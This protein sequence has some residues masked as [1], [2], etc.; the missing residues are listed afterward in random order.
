MS[1]VSFVGA[2]LVLEAA[3]NGVLAV[4]TDFNGVL[5]KRT[6]FSRAHIDGYGQAF[7]SARDLEGG[8]FSGAVLAGNVDPGGGFD[9]TG[10]TLTGATFDGAQCVGCNFT[11]PHLEHASFSR[12]DAPGAVFSGAT[13]TAVNLTDAWLDRLDLSNSGCAAAPGPQQRWLWP[14]GTRKRRG[15]RAGAIRQDQPERSLDRGRQPSLSLMGTNPIPTNGCDGR[16]LPA[17]PDSAP[18]IPAPCSAAALDACPTPTS[19]RFDATSIG[20]P[21]AWRPPLHPPGRPHSPSAD[22]TRASTTGRFAWS[23]RVPRRSWLGKP[24]STAPLPTD[25]CGDGGPAG[26]A[27]LGTTRGTGRRARRARCTWPTRRNIGFAYSTSSPRS[28]HHR[29]RQWRA[30]H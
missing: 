1:G 16:L 30:V 4:G 26:E 2:D 7:N 22:T 20:L 28:H 27:H 13:L 15:V 6:V 18:K 24:V 5:S 9:L 12:A 19:T 23:G 3:F 14:T 25:A 8:Y 17:N 29:G 11:G 10:A 21:S